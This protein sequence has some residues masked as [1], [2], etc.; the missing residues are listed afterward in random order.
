[1]IVGAGLA[2]C[3]SALM[4]SKR[5]F[6]VLLIEAR[7]DF[8]VAERKDSDMG[9]LE[10]STKRSI[11]LALSDRGIAALE[12]VGLFEEV[13]KLLIPMYGRYM[14]SIHN[15]ELTFQPY[16]TK[17]QHINSVSRLDLNRLLLEHCE[18][19]PNFQML[20]GEKV[21]DVSRDGVVTTASGRSIAS[22]FVVGADGA[23][24]RVRGSLL[25]YAR[26]DFSRRYVAHGYKELLMPANA[27]GE[28]ALSCPNG[29]HIWPRGQFM[30]IALPNPDK[31]FTCTLFAPFEGKN[32][33]DSVKTEA[34]A[35]DYFQDNF[36]DVI[37][38]IPDLITQ[39][40]TSP[41][42]PLLTVRCK[43]WNYNDKLVVLGDAAHAVV[44]FY[45]QGMNA[46]FE[47]CLV[48]DELWAELNGDVTK[49][50]PAFSQTRQPACDALADLSLEHYYEMSD[51]TGKKTFLYKKKLEA[52]LHKIA[53][54]WWV[55]EY[56]MVTFSR[57]PYHIAKAKAEK[58]DRILTRTF[59]LGGL[60]VA[61][62]AIVATTSLVSAYSS[63]S[64]SSSSLS[65]RGSRWMDVLAKLGSLKH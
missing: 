46:A 2:G 39:Y 57:T 21:T 44:P 60:L 18:K 24:S 47:D 56:T 11:N 64:L 23:F 55:P 41:T 59:Q 58:Q 40:F 6:P 34:Q 29:L 26:A 5:G 36:P 3:M 20:F 65:S 42:S 13:S 25:R 37:S 62:A 14:H 49:V 48:L 43:P 53:P 19:L 61:G 50:L 51:S 35:T 54:S 32:G 15:S 16:G 1:V 17:D 10:N 9:R 7:E 31:S 38:L 12:R 30:L 63:S 4:F 45:G 33:F 22:K 8:R 27:Q 52:L 28:Y